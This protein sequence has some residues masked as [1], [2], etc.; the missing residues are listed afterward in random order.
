[1]RKEDLETELRRLGYQYNLSDESW[2]LEEAGATV[3]VPIIGMGNYR[4]IR[5][6]GVL[7]YG[8]ISSQQEYF[9]AP[10]RVS[11]ERKISPSPFNG[12]C[13]AVV[14]SRTAGSS[15]YPTIYELYYRPEARVPSINWEDETFLSIWRQGIYRTN[16]KNDGDLA[17][18]NVL[19][20]IPFVS[21]D[22]IGNNIRDGDSNLLGRL[23][24]Y[25]NT[26][27][28]LLFNERHY[29]ITKSLSE[30]MARII[31]PA[32]NR[33]LAVITVPPKISMGNMFKVLTGE[34]KDWLQ[35]SE[36]I[37]VTVSIAKDR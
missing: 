19:L 11:M 22:F 16:Y 5:E 7:N 6:V 23:S 17:E 18:L 21:F 15:I 29:I 1:M 2:K 30:V 33:D 28:R 14:K 32:G 24:D 8:V 36:H 31:R 37:P 12:R 3:T 26:K 27:E 9:T 34:G 35:L 13:D 4:K 20:D 10:G 25:L